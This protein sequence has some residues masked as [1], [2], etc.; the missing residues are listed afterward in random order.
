MEMGLDMAIRTYSRAGQWLILR[1]S[2]ECKVQLSLLREVFI[3]N[4]VTVGQTNFPGWESAY[5]GSVRWIQS[6]CLALLTRASLHRLMSR[7]KTVG[8]LSSSRPEL[9]QFQS[10]LVCFASHLPPP[11]INE[12]MATPTRAP[13]TCSTAELPGGGLCRTSDDA[14]SR[15]AASAGSASGDKSCFS[16]LCSCERAGVQTES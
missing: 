13:R 7:Y 1:L 16:I 3:L 12:K 10:N 15:Q 5:E 14:A 8:V 11:L 4:P 6:F 2:S 9:K